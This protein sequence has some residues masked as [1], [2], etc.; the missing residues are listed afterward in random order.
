MP[1]KTG[2]CVSLCAKATWNR[3]PYRVSGMGP[4]LSDIQML[5]STFDTSERGGWKTKIILPQ[6]SHPS[7][8]LL[9]QLVPLPM[10]FSAAPHLIP[11]VRLNTSVNH[12]PQT[13][14]KLEHKTAL[15]CRRCTPLFPSHDHL[16]VVWWMYRLE[17]VSWKEMRELD[18]FHQWRNLR[19]P[20]PSPTMAISV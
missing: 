4:G 16:T 1:E 20:S 15:C 3:P 10:E 6:R 13:P 14:E 7:H 19:R 5:A 12:N 18:C 9:F 8:T 11:Q 17:I 2:Q